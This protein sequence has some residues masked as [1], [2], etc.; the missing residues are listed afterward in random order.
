MT[1]AFR[2]WIKKT[3]MQ[4]TPHFSLNEMLK[5]QT[6][7]RLKIAEQF[8][9]SPEVIENL[10]LLCEKILEPLRSECGAITINSGYRS[11]KT[12]R[13]VGGAATSQHLLG[14]AADIESVS[15]KNKLLFKKIQE[16]NLPFDQLIW[17]YGT[18][19]EPE[20]VHVSFGPRNRRQ[21]LY[22]PKNLAP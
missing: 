8:N 20:W 17:E 3:T 16:L 12:N 11:P 7:S 5:S 18:K 19:T 2:P 21:I 1:M 22:I 14:Q 6:A 4:L 10:R 13:A 15:F 9:P